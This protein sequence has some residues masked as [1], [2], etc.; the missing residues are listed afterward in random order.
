MKRTGQFALV[1]ISILFTL[2][3]AF[4]FDD[5]WHKEIV[6]FTI[7]TI[8]AWF[9]GWQYDKLKYLTGKAEENE[10]FYRQLI[11]TM[12][13]PVIIQDYDKI[14]YANKAAQKLV[15]AESKEEIVG[16]SVFDFME[17]PDAAQYRKILDATYKEKLPAGRR[18]QKITRLDGKKIYFEVSTLFTSFQGRKAVFSIGQDVTVKKEQADLLLQKSEKLALVGQMAAGIAHE[19]RNPLTSIK[20]FIQLLKAEGNREYA[21]I[22]ISELDRINLIVGEFLVLAKPAAAVYKVCDLK[23]LIQELVILIQPQCLIHNVQIITGLELEESEIWCE[24]NQ[25]KQ[26]FIN[27]IKN[28]AEAMPDGG[29]ITIKAADRKDGH[30]AVM[31]KDEGT[32]I[33]PDRINTLG[34]PFYTTKEKGT[35]LGLMTSFKIIENHSGLVKVSSEVNKGTVFEI[36][37][38]KTQVEAKGHSFN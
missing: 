37:L 11:E 15:A 12:P 21:D 22:A 16:R 32:G 34:E 9:V 17:A 13:E 38:P 20:G 35:G 36:I 27:M 1:S 7:A 18:E 26:V 8:I 31:I 4:I 24:E 3:Q 2:T 29:T 10:A 30:V 28:S 25:L 14:V 19:I 6:D 23:K 33:P 5:P